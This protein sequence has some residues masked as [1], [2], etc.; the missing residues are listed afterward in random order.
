MNF[1]IATR[2]KTVKVDTAAAGYTKLVTGLANRRVRVT[3]FALV[4][5]GTVTAKFQEDDGTTKTDLTGAMPMVAN[6]QLALAGGGDVP[7]LQAEDGQDLGLTLSAAVQV[8]GFVSYTVEPT[9]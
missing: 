2:V 8:S 7:L 9:S 3:S 4:A 5:G 6:T 1:R